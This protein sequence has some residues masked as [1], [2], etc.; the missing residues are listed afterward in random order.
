MQHVQSY[1]KNKLDSLMPN[2]YQIRTGKLFNKIYNDKG[3]IN[4]DTDIESDNI[5][6]VAS[7]F[8]TNVYSTSDDTMLPY[9]ITRTGFDYYINEDTGA[10][11]RANYNWV[12]IG[13]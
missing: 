2:N 12:A 4:F 7:T 9:N 10:H 13:Y 1:S 6:I 8:G 5:V 11:G 3:H